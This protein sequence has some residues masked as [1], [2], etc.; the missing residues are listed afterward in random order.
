MSSPNI[1][2]FLARV[3]EI[4]VMRVQKLASNFTDLDVSQMMPGKMLRARLAGRLIEG[5]LGG[6][7][8]TNAAQSSAAIELTHTA[9][10][11]HDDIIDNADVRRGL[12][13]MW[14]VTGT[15]GAVLI[16]DALLCEAMELVLEIENGKT[17]PDFLSKL[18]EVITA[19]AKAELTFRGT[20]LDRETCL[21]MA[22]GKTGPLFAF[23]AGAC[24][25]NDQALSAA[26][27]ESGY[28]IGTAYQ[29]SD[30]LLDRIGDENSV[31][32]TLRT[33]Q[34]RGKFTLAEDQEETLQREVHR[35]CE[36]AVSGLS[37]WPDA[38]QSVERYLQEDMQ[39]LFQQ[40]LNRTT[41]TP[42][43]SLR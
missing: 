18:K 37:Q 20:V 31:G 40:I 28:L 35:M 9:S 43:D 36:L 26:L 27:A 12:P 42:E 6:S 29:L 7:D 34:V 2:D 21:E 8:W 39:P 23:T 13:A 10:L 4:I 41:N 11:C 30:D 22:R 14:R 1:D 24:E 38:Q 25:S 33:D 16:G 3:Q 32:K 17:L 15:S 5:G 19:E